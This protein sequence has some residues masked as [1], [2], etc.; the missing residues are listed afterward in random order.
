M[1]LAWSTIQVD[2]MF[3]VDCTGV[4]LRAPDALQLGLLLSSFLPYE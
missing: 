4:I 2:G 3:N 1:L